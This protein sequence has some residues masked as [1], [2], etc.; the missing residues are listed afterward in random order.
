MNRG[1]DMTK[2]RTKKLAARVSK[3]AAAV[4]SIIYVKIGALAAYPN[5]PRRNDSAI[6]RMVRSI[7]EF[8]FA[9]PILATRDGTIIDGHLRLKAAQKLKMSEVPVIWCDR[10]NASQV[11]A[12]RLMANRSS[13]W[14][15]WDMELL[16]LEIADLTDIGYDTDLTGFDPEEIAK[17]QLNLDEALANEDAVPEK[18]QVPVSRRGDIF[19]LGRHILVCGDA[20]SA[21]DA[22][23]LLAGITPRML[24][25]DPPYG[26]QYDPAWR[27]RAFGEANRSIG[28]VQNDDRVDWEDAIRLYPGNIAYMFH[29]GTKTASVAASLEAYGFEIRTQIIWVKPHFVIGRGHYHVQHEP[30]WYAVRKGCSANWRGG[31]K[32]TTVWEISNG[33][34][35][36]GPRQP[37]NALTGH[38]TQKPVELIRRPILNHTKHQ[39]VIYD[40]FVGSGTTIIAAETTGRVALAMDIDPAYIDVAIRRWQEFTGRKAILEGTDKTFDEI[41]KER[42]G[43]A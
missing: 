25:S 16:R 8:G 41:A 19:C 31:R 43:K 18:P 27:N 20:T 17:L 1:K 34:S 40:P 7:K 4:L 5:N 9:I 23:R 29:A 10:W 3:I 15:E 37:E 35:Q 28:K 30:C 11:K 33:L 13:A 38:G 21:E 26:V 2:P 14:A 39:E 22:T 32:Q 12:F 6:D 24:I 36:G 42:M